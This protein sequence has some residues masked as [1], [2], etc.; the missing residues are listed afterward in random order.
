VAA[1]LSRQ[2][3]LSLN[4]DMAAAT[5]VLMGRADQYAA[6]LNEALAATKPEFNEE[7]RHGHTNM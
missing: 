1:D 6:R 5:P 4:G 7:M 3:L 2:G